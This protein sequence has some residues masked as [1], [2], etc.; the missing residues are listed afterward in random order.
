MKI[1]FT[2]FQPTF[3][4]YY[5]IKCRT[6]CKSPEMDW[7]KISDVVRGN[8]LNHQFFCIPGESSTGGIKWNFVNKILQDLTAIDYHYLTD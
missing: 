7:L 5:I 2:F 3:L 1:N 4:R 6:L 8:W